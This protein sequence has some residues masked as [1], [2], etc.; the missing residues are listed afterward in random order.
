M[1]AKD[2]VNHVWENLRSEY[3]IMQSI[4]SMNDI[5]DDIPV[6]NEELINAFNDKIKDLCEEYSLSSCCNAEIIR[7]PYRE[8]HS[9]LCDNTYE[10]FYNEYCSECGSLID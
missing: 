10:T 2:I 9:E 8:Y 5:L 3:D 4:D 6:E 1:W 7:K